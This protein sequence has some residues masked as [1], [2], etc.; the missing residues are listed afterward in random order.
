MSEAISIEQ[1]G[2][3][4]ISLLGTE[5]QV[6]PFSRRYPHFGLADAYE[7]VGRVGK[8][9][10][11]QGEKPIGRKIGFTNRAIWADLGISAP[12]WNYVFDKTVSHAELGR[13]E[14]TL[15]KMP[16]PRIEPE[17][18]VHLAS[19]PAPGMATADLIKCIDWVAPGFEVVYSIFPN[20]DFT[21]ADAAAA[22]G[23]HGALVVGKKLDLTRERAERT[24]Q[25]SNFAV[26]LENDKGVRRTG[27]A[28]NVLGG[29]L[30]ALKFLVVDLVRYPDCEPLRGGELVTTGT[31]T[32]A[33]PARAGE[34]WIAEFEGIALGPLQLHFV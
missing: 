12:V 25:L 18:V 5:K 23:V 20:W 28:G 8:L 16:E 33:M 21:A 19:A 24:A 9:R 29:P 13:A 7:I 1:I 17:I 6:T 2:E 15:G 34:T 31:L 14:I 32:E 27:N 26:T 22:F 3:E 4:L 11:G 30:E 10:L